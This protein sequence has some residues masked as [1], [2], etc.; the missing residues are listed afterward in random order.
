[1]I[2]IDANLLIYAVN[3]DAPRHPPAREWLDRALSGSVPV[4]LPWIC[5]LA[6]LRIVTHSRVFSRPMQPDTAIDIVGE[7]LE[8]PIVD[9]VYPGDGHWP[10]LRNLLRTTGT[11][12][13]LTT[14]THIAAMA[15]ERGATVCSADHD[16]KRFPGVHHVNP[17]EGAA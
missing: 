15:I 9:A 5:L 13:N 6:F 10:I 12:G 3:S 11:G 14:D 1:M 16:F 2:L 8:Q 7:W 17:L 4:G